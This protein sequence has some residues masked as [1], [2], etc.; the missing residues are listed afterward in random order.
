MPMTDK[1]TP[2]KESA[3]RRFAGEFQNIPATWAALAAEHIDGDECLALPMWGTLF[4]PS[5]MD[6]ER[7]ERL[8][9]DPVPTD[10]PELIEFAEEH[11]IEIETDGMSIMA[12]AAS[13]PDEIDENELRSEILNAWMESDDEDAMLA[14][15]GWQDVGSTGFIAREIDGNLLLGVNG[16]GYSFYDSHWASLYDELGF[17]WHERSQ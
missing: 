11:G 4:M 17:K 6:R 10:V 8:L 16:C 13:D 15:A 2:E 1:I 14:S 5:G 7:I 9:C 12:L 3:I